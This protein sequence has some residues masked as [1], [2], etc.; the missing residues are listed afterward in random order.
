MLAKLLADGGQHSKE[1]C[2]ITLCNW[3]LIALDLEQVDLA[4]EKGRLA[5]AAYP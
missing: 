2:G 5:L 3:A 4:V 1:D